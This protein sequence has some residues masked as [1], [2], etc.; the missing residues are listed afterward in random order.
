[1]GKQEM[2]TERSV[3]GLQMHWNDIQNE[4]RERGFRKRW[5]AAEEAQL[6]RA[7]EKL[8]TKDWTAI[9][10]VWSCVYVCVCVQDWCVCVCVCARF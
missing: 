9:V 6:Q 7:V 5:D 4:E 1:M 8:G 10:L 3:K 2:N